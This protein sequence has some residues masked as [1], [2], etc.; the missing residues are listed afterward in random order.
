MS[1]ESSEYCEDILRT[2][3]ETGRRKKENAKSGF[4]ISESRKLRGSRDPRQTGD[5]YGSVTDILRRCEA[6]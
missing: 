5:K 2:V 3:R 6:G 4:R 1:I